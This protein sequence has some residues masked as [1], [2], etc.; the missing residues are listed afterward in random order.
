MLLIA[1]LA[2]EEGTKKVIASILGQHPGAVHQGWVMANMLG[3]PAGKVSDPM[4]FFILMEG[5]DGSVHNVT[6]AYVP[7]FGQTCQF[8]IK[9]ELA[10]TKQKLEEGCSQK[11][12]GRPYNLGDS[13][14]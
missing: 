11:P 9:F 6:N 12:T 5:D 7:K 14:S 13:P 1:F 3:M 8:S 2:R 10:G 4:G